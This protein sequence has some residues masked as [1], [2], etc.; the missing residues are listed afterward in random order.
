MRRYGLMVVDLKK[1][2]KAGKA[3]AKEAMRLFVRLTFQYPFEKTFQ[4]THANC[5]VLFLSENRKILP[6]AF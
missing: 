6:V 2:I 4:N 5:S 1:I 3:A